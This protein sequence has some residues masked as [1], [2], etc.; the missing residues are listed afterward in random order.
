MRLG[1]RLHVT[2]A[3]TVSVIGFTFPSDPRYCL[4]VSL[5]YSRSSFLNGVSTLHSVVIQ[6]YHT[7]VSWCDVMVRYFGWEVFYNPII[8]SKGFLIGPSHWS[9]NFRRVYHLFLYSLCKKGHPGETRVVQ[10]SSCLRSDK[11]LTI[12]FP[13][14]AGIC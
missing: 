10:S 7:G 8:K 13:L 11:A 1:V 5:D 14:R 4:A 6:C 9:L 2:F 3:E 12:K